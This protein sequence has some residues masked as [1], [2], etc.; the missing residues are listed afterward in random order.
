MDTSTL[1]NALEARLRGSLPGDALSHPDRL[2]IDHSIGTLRLAREAVKRHKLQNASNILYAAAF[3]DICKSDGKFQKHINGVGYG[4]V[5]HSA[6]SSA[7]VW[8]YLDGTD[9]KRSLFEV[10]EPICRHHTGMKNWNTAAATWQGSEILCIAKWPISS[11]IR[12]S[13]MFMPWF[14]RF[15]RSWRI[16]RKARRPENRRNIR[17]TA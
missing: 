11:W 5:P 13:P 14:S 1:Q 8:S 9:T 2:L 4:H 6:P 12:A 15:W 10:A 7:C 16:T 17:Q 3:H